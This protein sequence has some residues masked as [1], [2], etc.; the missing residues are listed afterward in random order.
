MA[1]NHVTTIY[2]LFGVVFAILTGC[3]TLPENVQREPS[4]SL[5]S[6]QESTSVGRI[7]APVLNSKSGQSGFY[8]L[9]DGT[10]AFVARMKMADAAEKTLDLQYYIWHSDMTGVLLYDKLIQTADRGV[11]VRLLL[12]DLDTA[13]K[14]SGLYLIDLHPKIEVRVYNPVANRRFRGIGMISD[15]DRVNRR[16]HNKSMTA[17]NQLSI[18]GGRNI[19]NEYFGASSPSAFADLDVL[20]IGPIVQKISTVFDA[21]WNSDWVYPVSVFNQDAQMTQQHVDAARGRL[22]QFVNDAQD[23]SYIAALQESRLLSE[24]KLTEDEFFW[25]HAELLYDSPAKTAGGEMQSAT[26]MGPDL[27][28]FFQLANQELLIVSPYFVPGKKLVDFL[29]DLVDEGVKVKILTNSLAANDVG[30]VHAGYMRYRIPLLKRGIELYEYKP[31]LDRK[32]RSS[33]ILG[34]SKASLHAKTFAVDRKYMFV[35]SFNLDP[36]SALLNTELGVIFESEQVASKLSDSFAEKALEKAYRLELVTTPADESESGFEED[37]IKWIEKQNGELI[38]HD[39]E[40]ET[41]LLRRFLV[42]LMSIFVIESY[43]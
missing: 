38:T 18:I 22:K 21:Y 29:G 30:V 40:P 10:D 41:G 7:L 1:M 13:G 8:M 5:Q 39:T 26:H 9:G 24:E 35:G 11:R 4:Y 19:G 23:S 28:K 34:S 36:R 43:L 14:D 2:I 12:D 3:T 20:T 6:P 25:G 15:L 37:R 42:G 16:M 27:G 31:T 33:S 17:D 32:Q